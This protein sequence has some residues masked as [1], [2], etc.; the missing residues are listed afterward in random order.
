LIVFLKLIITPLKLCAPD[1]LELVAH[2]AV[3][4]EVS[5]GIKNEE[6][7]HEAGETEEPGRGSEVRT[8]AS[9]DDDGVSDDEHD[10]HEDTVG[11]EE[12]CTVD[13]EPGEVTEKEHKDN[14]DKDSSKIHLIVSGAVTV[15]PNMGIPESERKDENIGWTCLT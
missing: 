13:D 2:E 4:D 3:D 1:S 6:P 7:V 15:G 10:L 14:A 5:G 11:H 12:L 8:P 9:V